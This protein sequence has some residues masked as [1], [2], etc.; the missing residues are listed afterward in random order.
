MFNMYEIVDGVSLETLGVRYTPEEQSAILVAIRVTR[1][2]MLSDET[3]YED[4]D[5]LQQL[6]ALSMD[7]EDEIES[8]VVFKPGYDTFI[9]EYYLPTLVRA[10]TK[11]TPL[12]RDAMC[13][14]FQLTPEELAVS[15]ATAI[16]MLDEKFPDVLL[17]MPEDSD[18]Q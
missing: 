12:I 1:E 9:K 15:G 13:Q 2:I 11:I 17:S 10:A 16:G 4:M 5:T 7:V 8:G 3:S 18:T 6:I 14:R